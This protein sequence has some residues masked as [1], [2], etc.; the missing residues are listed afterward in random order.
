[1]LNVTGALPG[2][3][4]G[5]AVRRTVCSLN[6][7]HGPAANRTRPSPPTLTE[8]TVIPFQGFTPN[9]LEMRVYGV[10]ALPLRHTPWTTKRYVPAGVAVYLRPSGSTSGKRDTNA[11]SVAVHFQ[12]WPPARYPT[13]PVAIAAG[14]YVPCDRLRP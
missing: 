9:E 6:W 11:S 12:V 8:L 3:N 10:S 5:R 13:M 4:G 2:L 14:S 1:M 7:C